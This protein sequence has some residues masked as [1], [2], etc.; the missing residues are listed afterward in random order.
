MENQTT[1]TAK[2]EDIPKDADLL[3]SSKDFE[4]EKE[5]EFVVISIFCHSEYAKTEKLQV[6]TRRAED[7]ARDEYLKKNNTLEGCPDNFQTEEEEI[8]F[9]INENRILAK[10]NEV[11]LLRRESIHASTWKWLQENNGTRPPVL[12][13]DGDDDYISGGSSFIINESN[14]DGA[15]YDC[16]GSKLDYVPLNFYAG[17]YLSTAATS[18]SFKGKISYFWFIW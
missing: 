17:K 10:H 15:W 13:G 11:R 18:D 9:K 4:K 7:K 5:K 12:M 16:N 3:K 14:P 2:F 8:Q 1:P 6:R